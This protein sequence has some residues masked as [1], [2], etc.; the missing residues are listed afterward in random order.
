MDDCEV[1][2]LTDTGADHS[3][4]SSNLEQELKKVLT[5]WRGPH[6]R[7]SGGQVISP[8][9]RCTARVGLHSYTY[10]GEF[11]VPAEC[12]RDVILRANVLRAKEAVVDVSSSTVMFSTRGAIARK[13][14]AEVEV[15]AIRVVDDDVTLARRSNVVAFVGGDV[16]ENYERLTQG[17]INLLLERKICAVRGLVHVMIVARSLL[18]NFRKQEMPQQELPL[19]P[20]IGSIGWEICAAKTHG[21]EASDAQDVLELVHRCPDLTRNQKQQPTDFLANACDFFPTSSKV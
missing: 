18:T 6:V 2:A 4:I 11:I 1:T 14:P 10:V 20:C 7:T 17:N 5:Q 19:L 9:G 21:R 13:E 8:I 15:R 16:P 3:V 12:L